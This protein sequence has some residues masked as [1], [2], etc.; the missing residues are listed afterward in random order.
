VGG[1]SIEVTFEVKILDKFGKV[2]IA[3][4]RNRQE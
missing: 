2:T 4:A 1:R 3:R